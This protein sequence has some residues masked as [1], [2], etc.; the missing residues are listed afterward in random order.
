MNNQITVSSI[1]TKCTATVQTL[2]TM[3]IV[4]AALLRQVQT[5][6]QAAQT[7]QNVLALVIPGMA[8]A[9]NFGGSLAYPA[10]APT[11]APRPGGPCRV[12]PVLIRPVSSFGADGGVFAVAGSAPALAPALTPAPTLAFALTPGLAAALAVATLITM[13]PQA[14]RLDNVAGSF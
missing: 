14:T 9:N 6:V 5:N 10:P 11:H 8:P 12:A 4:Q 2:A 1:I 3:P 13:I 7:T